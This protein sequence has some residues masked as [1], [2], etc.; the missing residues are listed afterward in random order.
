MKTKHC[1]PLQTSADTTHKEQIGEQGQPAYPSFEQMGRGCYTKCLSTDAKSSPPQASLSFPLDYYTQLSGLRLTGWHIIK[2][3]FSATISH[4][5]II[6]PHHPTER[7][8]LS[9]AIPNCFRGPQR[10]ESNHRLSFPT[11]GDIYFPFLSSKLIGF[12]F[13]NKRLKIFYYSFWMSNKR[14][15]K[16]VNAT[17]KCTFCWTHGPQV[18]VTFLVVNLG[19]DQH[20]YTGGGSVTNP[21]I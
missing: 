5:K 1:L 7:E 21:V 20:L 15:F 6:L 11:K 16:I 8:N 17:S 19:E 13:L 9:Q 14:V 12:F 18:P 2:P 4:I 3:L 10:S